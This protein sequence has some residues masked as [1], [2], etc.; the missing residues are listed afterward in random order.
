MSLPYNF[1]ARSY[2]IKV[3][4]SMDSGK[5]KRG[6]CVWHR[7]SGKDKTFLNFMIKKLNERVGVYFY[8]FPTYAQGKKIL[9]DGRDRDGF[10][11]M[12][13]FPDEMIKRRNNQDLLL[14]LTNGSIFQ[15]I[16]TDK[17][18]GIVGTNPIGCIFSEYSLQD[19]LAWKFI[20][21]ILKE[22]GGWGLF[23][24]TPRGNNHAKKLYDMALK[25]NNWFCEKL[26]VDDT[27]RVDGSPV[28]SK[29]DI[30]DERDE[31]VDE[32]FIQQEYYC[33]FS[34]CIQGNYYS[35]W[36]DIA[37]REG[38]ICNVPY[39][40]LI[41]VET[42]WD[43]GVGDATGIWF[44]QRVG[45]EIRFI[46]YYEA[47]GE[48]L[49]YYIK[50]L[51]EKP[52][53]YSNHY[54]PHDIA[55]R[56]FSTGKS[57]RD[58]ALEL[59]INF[60]TVPKLPIDDGISAIRNI[61]PMCWFDKIKCSQGLEALNSYHKEYDEDRKEF[62]NKPHHDWCLTSE[63]YLLTKY[64]K[65]KIMKLPNK[66]EV[67]TLC[68]WKP[69]QNP[70]IT[71][72][73]AI[74]VEIMF[75]DG[76]TVKCTLE[77]LFLT[78]NGWKFARDLQKNTLILS[79]LTRLPNILRVVYI[80]FIRATNIIDRAA[81]GYIGWRGK[82]LLAKYRKIVISIIGMVIRPIIN[83]PILSVYQNQNTAEIQE[84]KDNRI[85]GLL[86]KQE[87]KPL[88]GINRRQADYGIA[89]KQEGLS[90][91]RNG[92]ENRKHVQC[93][94]KSLWHWFVK[95]VM[96][97]NIACRIVSPLHVINVTLLNSTGE[98]WCLTVPGT[99]EYSLYNGAIM[100]NSSHGSDALRTF[101]IGR[102]DNEEYNEEDS[103]ELVE[104]V[105]PV[106]GI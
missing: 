33:S 72:K 21:P 45:L 31:G 69:Y 66:G 94:V 13:H 79:S 43:I 57:R 6:V 20:R 30:Q 42:S 102:V 82:L 49:P 86:L 7:R 12:G 35:K 5:I 90:H 41:E 103:Y 60:I 52:Y 56:E 67:M 32:D 81:K 65:C 96:P 15:I 84:R 4:E 71:R 68:G 19:P 55:V 27:K 3:L 17:I 99:E 50:V 105:S 61:L 70:R 87:K 83:Y 28:Y 46:D 63:T 1:K 80:E 58:S 54:A 78:E 53:V 74:L 9:W 34:G 62:K 97:K 29:Q 91:G 36:L 88:N 73:N 51:R 11:Y 39:D 26:T 48:G 8:F 16:G 89:D 100:H 106:T 64:G 14:E 95:A 76:N 98:V 85:H 59:G 38:R 75:S 92:N 10:P 101:A 18:D 22:N 24:F 93:V 23:N 44:I 37:E 104:P 40:P 25:N 47:T 2:Q 77:H